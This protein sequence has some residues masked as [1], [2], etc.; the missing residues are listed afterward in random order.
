MV[1]TDFTKKVRAKVIAN[2]IIIKF[3]ALATTG[4]TTLETVLRLYGFQLPNLEEQQLRLSKTVCRAIIPKW[5][6]RVKI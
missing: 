5:K 1:P 2:K 4:T 3:F 6:F